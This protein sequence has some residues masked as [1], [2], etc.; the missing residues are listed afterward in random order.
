MYKIKNEQFFHIFCFIDL[1]IRS[2]FFIE[3]FPPRVSI[4]L[5]GW[6]EICC[7]RAIY[8]PIKFNFGILQRSDRNLRCNN[9]LNYIFKIF[10]QSVPFRVKEALKMLNENNLF[11]SRTVWQDLWLQ[12]I[13]YHFFVFQD[14]VNI[15]FRPTCLYLNYRTL[16]LV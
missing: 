7:I 3:V 14:F 13:F 16:G 15:T 1:I 4:Q 8:F 2:I 12:E 10:M 9:F 11:L 5:L 6:V